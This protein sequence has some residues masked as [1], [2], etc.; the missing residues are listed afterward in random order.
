MR[1]SRWI[2]ALAI[3]AT[4]TALSLSVLAGWQRGG[5]WPERLIWIA[6][7]VVLVTSAHLL[8]ALVR[9]KAVCRPG[10]W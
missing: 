10:D 8:P 9:G 3:S 2:P 1:T 7:G 6:I 4:A 5:T